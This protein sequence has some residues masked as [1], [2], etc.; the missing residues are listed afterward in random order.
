M[1]YC[2]Y[3]SR[4]GGNLSAVINLVTMAGVNFWQEVKKNLIIFGREMG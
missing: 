2:D 1:K 3:K 4:R